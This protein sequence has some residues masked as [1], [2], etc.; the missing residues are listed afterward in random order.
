MNYLSEYFVLRISL[1]V[2]CIEHTII[3]I[4]II[5][6]I[7]VAVA[8]VTSSSSLNAA[9][10]VAAIKDYVSER[11]RLRLFTACQALLQL[12]LLYDHLF[13]ESYDGG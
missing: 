3:T 4:I 11:S 12:F 8:V 7:I 1:N 10:V 6:I 13:K 2:L 5:I 9:A